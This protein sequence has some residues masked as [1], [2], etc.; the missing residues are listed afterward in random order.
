MPL[1]DIFDCVP[2]KSGQL[3][4]ISDSSNLAQ[5][6]NESFQ[7]ACVMLF[8]IGKTEA[9]LFY[10]TAFFALKPAN[11]NDQ[12]D[13]LV[14]YRQHFKGAYNPTEPDYIMRFTIWTPEVI[15]VNRPVED[16]LTFKKSVLMC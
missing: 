9:R 4:Y 15:A 6:N 5:V 12:F 8:R 1:M 14:A 11:F 10:S 13:L 2:A 16:G 7:R 3:C